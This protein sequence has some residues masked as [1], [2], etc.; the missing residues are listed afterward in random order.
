MLQKGFLRGRN[1]VQISKKRFWVSFALGLVSSFSIYTFL[2]L[3]R[4]ISRTFDFGE[5]NW[6]WIIESSERYWQNFNFA[7]IS[8]VLGNA[9]FLLNI[10]RKP[11]RKIIQG[12]KRQNIIN[13]QRFLSFGFFYVFMKFTLLGAFTVLFLET[14]ISKFKFLLVFIAVVLFLES[15]KSIIRYFRKNSYIPLLINF[16][17]IIGLSF[18]F[19]FTSVF[20][21]N[22]IDKI[23]HETNPYVDLPRSDYVD[24]SQGF[25]F[26]RRFKIYVDNDKVLYNLDGLK[27]KDLNQLRQDLLK[28]SDYL[29]IFMSQ[30]L[31]LISN[32]ISIS[33]VTKVEKRLFA[34]G[35]I[36][37]RYITNPTDEKTI[38]RFSSN[39]IN[40]NLFFDDIVHEL[41]VAPLLKSP[42]ESHV[43]TIDISKDKSYFFNKEKVDENDLVEYFL[44]QIDSV[45]AFNYCLDETILFKSILIC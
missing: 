39:G 30:I 15:W 27:L 44:K 10:F 3:L 9:L 22:K 21:Y 20:D 4:L 5:P 34:L 38:S 7:I 26:E 33:E 18:C 35:I 45:T 6:A 37:V 25:P 1:K 42:A 8:L 19:A 41:N 11:D 32:D 14:G 29:P 16:V 17:T 13:D 36:S 2:C 23:L 12:Y 24:V 28:Q 31:L 43:E 40:K